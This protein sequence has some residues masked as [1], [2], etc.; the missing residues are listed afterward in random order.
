M[1]NPQHPALWLCL[2]FSLFA[3]AVLIQGK[4][5]GDAEA[6]ERPANIS[7]A[8]ACQQAK[9]KYSQTPDAGYLVI[10]IAACDDDDEF[11]DQFRQN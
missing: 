4:I 9:E 7:I 8:E 3:L 10:A 6:K 5:Q 11:L 1:K 2:A